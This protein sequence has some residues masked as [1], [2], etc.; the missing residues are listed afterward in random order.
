MIHRVPNAL[1]FKPMGIPLHDLNENI[2]TLDEAEAMRLADIE[3]LSQEEGA[4]KMGISRATFGRILNQGHQ[5]VADAILH[6]KA[7][8][9]ENP[10]FAEDIDGIF[11][12]PD[13]NETYV[14]HGFHRGKKCPG[15][16]SDEVHLSKGFGRGRGM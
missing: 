10:E 15:C 9:I 12:C 6:G 4:E 13:C 8:R 11:Y 3:G 5:K 1:Y 16:H 7:L 2:L 14:V